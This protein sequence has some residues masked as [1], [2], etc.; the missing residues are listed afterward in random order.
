L[1][2]KEERL[3]HYIRALHTIHGIN[4]RSNGGEDVEKIEEKCKI[5]VP[6]PKNV[7]MK[8]WEKCLQKAQKI[9]TV[10]LDGKPYK[11]LRWHY[12]WYE[13]KDLPEIC[14]DCLAKPGQLHVPGCDLERC[15]KCGEQ[16]ISCKCKKSG[17]WANFVVPQDLGFSLQE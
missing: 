14:H 6:V 15:P 9:K 4:L 10:T 12:D 7:W 2:E 13:E 3:E 17:A 16:L 5:G 11:R 1:T 8:M